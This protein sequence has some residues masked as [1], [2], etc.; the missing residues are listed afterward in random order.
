MMEREEVPI[1]RPGVGP[2]KSCVRCRGS[3]DTSEFYLEYTKDKVID[4]GAYVSRTI[5]I[6]YFVILYNRCCPREI[7]V[8]TNLGYGARHG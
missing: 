2:A 5:D 6:K 7:K 1:R 3:F 4:E 8:S